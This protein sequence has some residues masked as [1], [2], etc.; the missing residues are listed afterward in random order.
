MPSG[1]M[2]R[3]PFSRS[4]RHSQDPT[5]T[6]SSHSRHTSS[7]VNA[8]SPPPR[9]EERR[10]LSVRA[11][12]RLEQRRNMEESHYLTCRARAQNYNPPVD[13]RLL[14]YVSTYD[15]NLMC[16]ICRCPFVDPVILNECDHCF[17]RD[18]I[19][20]CWNSDTNYTP[21][22]PR[23]DCPTCRTPAKLGPRSATSKILVNLVD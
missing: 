15:S 21:L 1:L 10:S 14:D 19:R 12:Q 9:N 13:L 7:P 11:T 20:Q 23:G 17:C 4:P 8:L 6:L 18:C 16:A 3:S 22:G 2:S 5:F